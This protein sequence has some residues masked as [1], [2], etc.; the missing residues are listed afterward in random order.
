MS[1]ITALFEQ[2]VSKWS[3]LAAHMIRIARANPDLDVA[4]AAWLALAALA[5]A[6]EPH[7]NRRAS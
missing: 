4:T 6:P 5:E 3:F 2:P 1:A 7:T